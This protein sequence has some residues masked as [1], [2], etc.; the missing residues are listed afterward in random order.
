MKPVGS[1]LYLAYSLASLQLI[2]SNTPLLPL[3]N[4]R[5][6]LANTLDIQETTMASSS[7]S[8][9]STESGSSD[10]RSESSSIVYDHEPFAQF[11]S[12]VL[13][14]AQSQIWPH[15]D[16]KDNITVE[17]L[18]GGTY[19]RIIGLT[20]TK[21][22]S[23]TQDLKSSQSVEE[24]VPETAAEYILRIPRFEAA[25]V[26]ADVAALLFVKRLLATEHRSDIP[27]ILV[28]EVIAFDETENN[29]LGNPFMVQERLR[30]VS[31]LN[32]YPQLEHEQQRRVAQDLGRAY[33]RMLAVSSTQA[34]RL[35]LP[36][37]NKSL[38]AEIHVT[39]WDLCG[40]IF[41]K[42]ERKPR[43]SAPYR[44]GR[45]TESVLELLAWTFQ[46]Q[47]AYVRER[48]PKDTFRPA[49][50]DQFCKM[51]SEMDAAGY[52]KD[53]D[54]YFALSHLDLEP[55]NILVDHES[56]PGR[57][58]ISGI[59]DWDSAVLAPAFMSCTPPMWIWSWQED[60]DED[61]RMANEVPATNEQKELK[62]EFESAAGPLYIQCAYDPVYRLARRLV[63]FAIDGIW[64]TK[65]E[66]E[67]EAMLEEWKKLH[68]QDA[69]KPTT[70]DDK[71]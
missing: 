65:D 34:G 25:Q 54:G 55:R 43:T 42:S 33:R 59:L 31:L 40:F 45:A 26:D 30:G 41:S 5:R 71:M 18:R 35:V 28:P 49:K 19:N 16:V 20:F 60:E 22:E 32:V 50:F 7:A 70:A 58:V 44:D 48:L 12:K 61:K 51:V 10:A 8:D 9:S 27:D 21:S 69:V 23:E 63:R 62:A 4:I 11:Q 57:P 66:R 17:R 47:K 52:F 24:R 37:D 6:H 3:H 38:D 15:S 56:A 1:T 67:A 39:R 64:S 36:D 14:F 53:L 29:T 68:R 2:L 13:A 46:E